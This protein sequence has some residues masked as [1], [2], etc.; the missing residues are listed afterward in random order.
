[1]CN[2]EL[3]MKVKIYVLKSLDLT[4]SLICILLANR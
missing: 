3:M 1:M 4:G 2:F